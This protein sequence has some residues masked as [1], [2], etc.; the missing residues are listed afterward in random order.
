MT[1]QQ[2]IDVLNDYC[3]KHKCDNG[4]CEFMYDC[5][6]RIFDFSELTDNELESFV[7]R[8]TETIQVNQ[9][10]QN[11]CEV[12]E[13]MEQVKVLKQIT[14]ITYPEKMK[15][16]LP[17]KEFVK[18]IL[19]KGYKAEVQIRTFSNDLDVVVYKEVEM[20]E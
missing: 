12:G 20:E 8:I 19:E 2:M 7:E 3:E 1:R 17:I 4:S 5:D 9:E 10:P 16:V 13:K 18:N 15:D 11:T 14:K 6:N